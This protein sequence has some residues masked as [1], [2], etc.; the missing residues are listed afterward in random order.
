MK[1]N[2]T[3]APPRIQGVV[4]GT[5]VE[6]DVIGNPRVD[7]PGCPGGPLEARTM[8]H[9]DSSKIGRAL[10]LSFEEGDPTKPMVLGVLHRPGTPEPKSLQVEVDGETILLTGRKEV[11]LRC[12]KASI[13]L[14]R[15]G[16]VLLRGAYLS[17]RSSGV[18]R[19]KGGSVQIN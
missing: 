7:Y 9:L 2:K 17:S 14:T 3:H 12:G 10:A 16:K 8:A 18:N 15:A 11:V 13:T 1:K 4:I 5:L 19:I 6:L